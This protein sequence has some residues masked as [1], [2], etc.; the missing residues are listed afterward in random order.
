MMSEMIKNMSCSSKIGSKSVIFPWNS[1]QI[2]Q[3][4][5]S[6]SQQT[7]AVLYMM[8]LKRVSNQV[9]VMFLGT[10]RKYVM[11][12]DMVCQHIGSIHSVYVRC[13]STRP[14]KMLKMVFL[15]M[16]N[17]G[18]RCRFLTGSATSQGCPRRGQQNVQEINFMGILCQISGI[19]Y[20]PS[21]H[22][23]MFLE[24]VI[25]H[26]RNGM[27]ENVQHNYIFSSVRCSSAGIEQIRRLYWTCTWDTEE[28]SL[29]TLCIPG[30]PVSH[31][32]PAH[33]LV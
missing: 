15:D 4:Q 12:L 17:T 11:F 10:V 19:M 13:F 8:F 2:C 29:C 18:Q 5:F 31:S 22:K 3:G 14:V 25:E 26:A 20:F 7:C 6:C 16:G 9:G 24:I 28:Q 32:L 33:M 1:E 23:M 30:T 27:S 21:I